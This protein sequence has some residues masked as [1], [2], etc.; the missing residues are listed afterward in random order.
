MRTHFLNSILLSSFEYFHNKFITNKMGVL[1]EQSSWTV[2]GVPVGLIQNCLD[3]KHIPSPYI[4]RLLELALLGIYK[5]MESLFFF[6]K[7]LSLLK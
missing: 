6:H 3:R 4:I 2:I 5:D 7:V 1:G